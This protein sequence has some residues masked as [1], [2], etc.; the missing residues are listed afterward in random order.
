MSND[1]NLTPAQYDAIN[2]HGK[3]ILVSAAA[4]SGKTRVLT[5]RIIKSLID[6]T[7]DLSRM[8]VVTFTR[9]AAAEMKGRIA[10]AISEKLAEDPRREHLSAQLLKLGSAQIS[11]IDSFF[12]K[13]VRNNFEKLGLT[14][15]FRIADDAE[16]IPLAINVMETVIDE[17]YIK[18]KDP[19]END[20][21]LSSIQNNRFAKSLDHLMSNRSDGKLNDLLL[22]ILNEFSPYFEGI[23]LL[24]K[25]ADELQADCNTDVIQSVCGK[26]ILCYYDELFE[27]FA[28]ELQEIEREL[29]SDPDMYQKCGDLM[30]TDREY[31]KKVNQAFRQGKYEDIKK[32]VYSFDAKAKFPS[33]RT[34]RKTPS[35]I[36]YQ[37]WRKQFR[38]KGV[39]A[40][41]KAFVFSS[42]EIRDQMQKTAELCKILYEL[43]AEFQKRML[44]EKKARGILE[45]ND[46]RAMVYQ[47]L[48]DPNGAPSEFANA[49]AAE[50]DAVY[51]DEYQDVD[52]IQDQIFSLIGRNRRF[53]V[54]DIKQSIYCF[55]GSEPS[56]FAAYR[57]AF[58]LYGTKEADAADGNTIFMSENFRCNA[59]IIDFTNTVCSFLF[60]AC[61]KSVGY[62]TEDNLRKSKKDPKKIP[63]G[64]PAPVQVAFFEK[65]PTKKSD[66]DTDTKTEYTQEDAWIADEI[67]RM[68]REEVRDNGEKIQPSD[69]AILVREKKHGLGVTKA[70]KE[71]A[72]PVSS[73][74]SMDFM[75][76][77][78]WTHLLNLL[79]AIDN[80]YR[81]IPL[82]E[83]LLSP[84]GGFTLEE[85]AHIRQSCDQNAALFD[86]MTAYVEANPHAETAKNVS[87]ILDWLESW[88]EQASVLPADKLLRLLCLDE[89]LIE[90]STSVAFTVLYDQARVYQRSSWCGLYGFLQH[91]EKL[92]EKGKISAAGFAKAEN[93]VTIMT[94][95]HSKG[96][97]I[98]IVFLIACGK[99]FN[100]LDLKNSIS[101]QKSTGL[102]TKLFQPTTAEHE[103]TFLRLATN[104]AIQMEEHEES[105]RTL[106]VALTRAQERLFVTGTLNGKAEDLE[107][108]TSCVKKG[109]RGLIL[110]C[111]S[112][113]RWMFA[114][115]N[116]CDE[117][118]EAFPC[119][120]QLIPFEMPHKIDKSE[121][122]K[123]AF[124]AAKLGKTAD[125]TAYA[126]AEI[127][128]KHAK[129]PNFLSELQ[130]IPTKAAASKLPPNLLDRIADQTDLKN[131][132]QAQIDLMS[133]KAPSFHTLLARKSAVTAAEIGTATHEFLEFCD[134]SAL[135]KNG[136][137]SEKDRL[138]KDGFMRKDSIDTVQDIWIEAF[139][140]SRVMNWIQSAK[141]IYREQKFSIMVPLSSL[142]ENEER[143]KAVANHMIYVQGSIDLV[144]EMPDEE[145]ILIDYKTDRILE[146]E[147]QN[148]AALTKR[149]NEAHG[150]QLAQYTKAAEQLFGKKP[151]RICLYLLA[152]GD[153]IEI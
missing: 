146:H 114:V 76:D 35:V 127:I 119:N 59:P 109:N 37:N 130:G 15:N 60:S 129:E 43:F 106:Y 131:A 151:N 84:I 6:K 16:V 143:A 56:I 113:L 86:A 135:C 70:L 53:M 139:M 24:K 47:M 5:E 69:I 74:I 13:L 91:F 52:S 27:C 61:E 110:S 85:I 125:A 140:K 23:E 90:H 95:H 83:F 111:S 11:T 124:E 93:A 92:M 45:H 51:I 98:P 36:K 65:P 14:A 32:A 4:G 55:R 87:A 81:D 29:L 54:G 25:N 120:F 132:L 19:S 44:E 79:R 9:A 71:R 38:E 62:R 64:Y 138:I 67:A 137:E 58:P 142:T 99:S 80:P 147:H 17:F 31:C 150:H 78:F 40:V 149:M 126:Y 22:R 101:F 42:D 123:A 104:L 116:H 112:Y 12:Q 82:S 21:T 89:K 41:Q 134:F 118:G 133:S 121:Q 46:V 18:Y 108:E 145:L 10:D 88:R 122:E 96:L 3:T 72:I 105:I 75:K 77:P 73:E 107:K 68:L 136:I 2:A 103:N 39:N 57:K 94:I 100:D 148:R 30:D 49:I 152:L 66:E 28:K 117:T 115:K 63:N 34:E 97:E 48:T 8:L 144:L 141:N 7:S 26:S 128:K 102:A 20:Q 33:I 50:Y 153:I 1:L